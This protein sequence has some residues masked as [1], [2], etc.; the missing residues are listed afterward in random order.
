MPTKKLVNKLTFT[1]EVRDIVRQIP[2]GQTMSYKE[3]A[4]EVNNPKAAR[5]VARIMAANFDKEIPCHRVIRTDGKLGNY[6]RGGTEA[7][8]A[9]LESEKLTN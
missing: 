6:N 5:A 3:V 9:I 4:I 2:I 8:R 1:E 7:K